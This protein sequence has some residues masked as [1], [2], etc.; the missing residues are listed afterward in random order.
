MKAE[1]DEEKNYA[2]NLKKEVE[3]L[4][5]YA[6]PSKEPR[7]S[8]G[9]GGSQIDGIIMDT[10]LFQATESSFMNEDES[11][12]SAEDSQLLKFSAIKKSYDVK[13]S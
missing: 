1:L 13:F 3:E 6:S 4:K 10:G 8:L 2:T 12:I 7:Y 9:Q 11:I 5:W